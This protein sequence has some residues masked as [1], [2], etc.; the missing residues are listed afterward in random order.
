MQ[1]NA[2]I[3]VSKTIMSTGEYFILCISHAGIN[4]S[5][6]MQALTINYIVETHRPV[7]KVNSLTLALSAHVLVMPSPNNSRHATTGCPCRPPAVSAIGRSSRD[8]ACTDVTRTQWR[9][10]AAIATHIMN[11]KGNK[12]ISSDSRQ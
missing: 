9:R 11:G 1:C 10:L 8:G 6:H 7:V 5:P 3:C 4:S 12:L 2:L